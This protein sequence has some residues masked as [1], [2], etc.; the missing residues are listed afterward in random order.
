[1]TIKESRDIVIDT[2]K[3]YGFEIPPKPKA[4]HAPS[5]LSNSKAWDETFIMKRRNDG[6]KEEL[7]V[8]KALHWQINVLTSSLCGRTIP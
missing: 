2:L 6:Y 4:L 5:V 3:E 8:W 1:M 7:R